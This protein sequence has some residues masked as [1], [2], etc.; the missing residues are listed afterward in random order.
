MKSHIFYGLKKLNSGF[1]SEET[2]YF[3]ES[4]FE[5][6][7]DRVEKRGLGIYGIEPW[8]NGNFHDVLGYTD[9]VLLH[10]IPIGTE[11]HLKNLRKEVWI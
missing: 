9:L 6:V 10:L 5:I 11:R 7:L 1:D 3:S 2:Y 8:M 4:D